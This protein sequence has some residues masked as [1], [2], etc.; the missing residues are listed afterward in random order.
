MT[1]AYWCVFI[2]ILLPTAYTGIAK[3]G[4]RGY[5]AK[6]NLAPREF[7]ERLK[8]FRKRANWVQMN[9]HE[10]IPAFMAATIIAHQIGG[11][12]NMI[13]ALAVAYIVL[14]LIYGLLYMANM[15]IQRTVVWTLALM[16]ILGMFFTA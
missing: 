15:G 16:C 7:L 10:S 4:G 9:T 14:R 5:Q 2:S 13:D 11:D 8:G 3:F 6:D 1:I 12:Q